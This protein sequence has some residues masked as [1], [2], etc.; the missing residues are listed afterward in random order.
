MMF[1]GGT[2]SLFHQVLVMRE[3]FHLTLVEVK[4]LSCAPQGK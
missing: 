2:V 3:E 4:F 1:S